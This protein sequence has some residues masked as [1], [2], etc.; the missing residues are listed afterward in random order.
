MG[1]V[2]LLRSGNY[3]DYDMVSVMKKMVRLVLSGPLT[4]YWVRNAAK[5]A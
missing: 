5:L 2:H 1:C 4:M 3:S